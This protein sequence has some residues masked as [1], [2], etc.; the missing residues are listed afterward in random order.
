MPNN[1]LFQLSFSVLLSFCSPSLFG[2]SG[3]AFF[4][5]EPEI[6][7]QEPG[8]LQATVRQVRTA[9]EILVKL[10]A[11]HYQHQTFNDTLSSE[12]LDNYID[13][14]DPAKAYFTEQDIASFEQYRYALDDGIRSGNLTPAFSMF[15]LYQIKATS[16]LEKLLIE[17]DDRVSSLDFARE[18]SIAL[19]AEDVQ[20]ARDQTML[21]NSCLLYTSPSPRDRG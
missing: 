3:I 13:Q 15:N 1:L 4:D 10:Q 8:N 14:L 6:N 9:E 20:W 7:H 17:L 18:E 16:Y 19:D 5:K 12:L 21:S 2:M 11:E